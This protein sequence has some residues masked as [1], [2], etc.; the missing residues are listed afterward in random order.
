M[1]ICWH[2][3]RL[4]ISAGTCRFRFEFVCHTSVLKAPARF[5]SWVLQLDL[6]C[7]HHH[8]THVSHFEESD[9]PPSFPSPHPPTPNP[10]HTAGRQARGSEGGGGGFEKE[11]AA[12][13]PF[14]G[15]AH[16]CVV[17]NGSH[18]SGESVM[19]HTAPHRAAYPA[20]DAHSVRCTTAGG[21]TSFARASSGRC[22]KQTHCVICWCSRKSSKPHGGHSSH[23]HVST[24]CAC[25]KP[26]FLLTQQLPSYSTPHTNSNSSKG[27]STQQAPAT[28][29]RLDGRQQ[30]G[31]CSH[32][33]CCV[34]VHC[35]V[36]MLAMTHPPSPSAPARHRQLCSA[37]H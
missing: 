5:C 30:L 24:I 8:S 26:A 32:R 28:C 3:G 22:V 31:D 15:T 25:S 20:S 16:H 34:H 4:A 14:L 36:L 9:T 21:Q 35:P 13:N 6:C 23:K 19:V 27:V 12:S 37:T 17:T 7:V 18:H 2:E 10:Q 33:V 1:C 11:T 29:N